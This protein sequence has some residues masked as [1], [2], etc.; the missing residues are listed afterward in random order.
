MNSKPIKVPKMF[1][2]PVIT[3]DN[4]TADQLNANLKSAG[5]FS[6]KVFFTGRAIGSLAQGA[7]FYIAKGKRFFGLVTVYD[8]YRL[9]TTILPSGRVIKQLRKTVQNGAFGSYVYSD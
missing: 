4:V 5:D 7:I 3:L 1:E 9:E 8:R 2:G 6:V